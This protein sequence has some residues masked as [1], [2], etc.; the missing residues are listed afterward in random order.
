MRQRDF[1]L[2]PICLIGVVINGYWITQGDTSIS[3]VLV[4][5]IASMGS[6]VVLLNILEKHYKPKDI[7]Q[8]EKKI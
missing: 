3:T 7:I 2:V 4:L 5:I 6:T 8:K 1:I